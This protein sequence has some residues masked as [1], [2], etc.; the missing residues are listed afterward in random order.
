MKF[1]SYKYL[2]PVILVAAR[3]HAADELPKGEAILDKFIEA[4]GGKTAYQKVHSEVATGYMEFGAMQIKAKMTVYRAQPSFA[5]T[6]M[7]IEGMG[8]VQEGS[9]GKVAWSL[10]AMQGARLKEGDEKAES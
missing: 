8:K 2:A 3:L 9:D 4:T 5:Y 6:E 10:S 7:T 1:A